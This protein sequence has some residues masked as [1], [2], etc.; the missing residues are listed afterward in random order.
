MSCV[1]YFRTFQHPCCCAQGRTMDCLQQVCNLVDKALGDTQLPSGTPEMTDN[2]AGTASMPDAGLAAVEAV[3]RLAQR[4][5][6]A[7]HELHL[8]E[9]RAQW[10]GSGEDCTSGPSR[11]P[12]S[13]GVGSPGI[14]TG[15]APAEAWTQAFTDVANMQQD[16]ETMRTQVQAVL[17]HHTCARSTRC[18]SPVRRSPS[19]LTRVG[20]GNAGAAPCPQQ[21][22][23]FLRVCSCTGGI[24]QSATCLGFQIVSCCEMVKLLRRCHDGSVM[25]RGTSAWICCHV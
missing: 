7:Q 18:T 14:R 4:F 6:E 19:P 9:D 20:T 2:C 17:Q 12:S 21:V 24:W 10:S 25:I 23:A 13:C 15:A 16:V 11:L 1:D 5:A 3:Q 22:C 8:S